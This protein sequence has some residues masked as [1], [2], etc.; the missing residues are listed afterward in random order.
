MKIQYNKTFLLSLNTG[1]KSEKFSIVSTFLQNELNNVGS[2]TH[3]FRKK[4][5]RER[6][7]RN[8]SV[9]PKVSVVP[10]EPVI[11]PPKEPVIVPPKEPNPNAWKPRNRKVETSVEKLSREINTILNKLTMDNLS[12]LSDQIIVLNSE[13]IDD[14]EIPGK[15][16]DII[17]D[18]IKSKAYIE[19]IYVPVYAKLCKKLCIIDDFRKVLLSKCNTEFHIHKTWNK[20][21]ENST[22]IEY[23]PEEE[24]RIKNKIK[25]FGIIS[26]I[27]ELYKVNVVSN[28]VISICIETLIKGKSLEDLECLS[29][30]CTSL[31][32][33]VYKDYLV[34]IKAICFQ[35]NTQE[36]LRIRVLLEECIR[37]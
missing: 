34:Q 7:T 26:F 13:Y 18:N 30:M 5:T 6:N 11:V 2:G 21:I 31:N 10:K 27:C 37:S 4:S 19:K 1:V 16:V 33:N 17:T 3:T 32:R 8:T 28:R 9:V 24:E 23:L 14:L 12:K 15:S 36:T 22:Q 20:Q 29:H 35:M 25:S